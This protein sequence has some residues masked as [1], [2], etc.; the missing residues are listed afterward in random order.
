M[1][2]FSIPCPKPKRL[3]GRDIF[4]IFCTSFSHLGAD[5]STQ[6]PSQY[7]LGN[8]SRSGLP[9]RKRIQFL[10]QPCQRKRGTFR[11]F[12]CRVQCGSH[13]SHAIQFFLLGRQL[14][15]YCPT[16]RRSSTRHFR[17]L[18]DHRSHL[19][20]SLAPGNYDDY[21]IS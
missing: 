6:S 9:R 19:G 7:R 2:R 3:C 18:L 8:V 1:G 17:S 16:S 5:H 4:T 20:H 14:C 15:S 12:N 21:Q 10:N 13:L 11:Q